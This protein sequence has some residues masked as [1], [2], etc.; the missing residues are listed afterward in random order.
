VNAPIWSAP[1]VT[2]FLK[3]KFDEYGIEGIK[4]NTFNPDNSQFQVGPFTFHPFRVTHSVPDSCGFAI[5]TPEGRV[6]HVPEHKMD[7]N[8]VGGMGIDIQKIRELAGNGIL[9]LASDCLGAN[10]TGFTGGEIQLEDNIYKVAVSAKNALFMTA[11][12]SNIGRFQ[13]MVNV[14]QRLGRKV[15]FVGRSIQKRPRKQISSGI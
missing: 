1:I 13:Q 8:P 15:V 7:E 3:D 9:S 11:I 2:E 12:S 14:S 4:L 10:K 5:D 6:F